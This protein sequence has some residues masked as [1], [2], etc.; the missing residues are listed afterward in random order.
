MR[1]SIDQAKTSFESSVQSEINKTE[2]DLNA[3]ASAA[4]GD[5]PKPEDNAKLPEK[6]V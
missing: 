6:A 2:A 3:A 4:A 1:E 5:P